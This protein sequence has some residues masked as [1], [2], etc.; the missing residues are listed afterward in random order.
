MK[1]IVFVLIIAPFFSFAQNCSLKKEIDK[2]SNEPKLTTGLVPLTGTVYLAIDANGKEIDF[3]FT[4]NNA[5]AKCFDESSTVTV[6]FNGR[7]KTNLKNTGATNC[8]GY[9][10]TTFRNSTTTPTV[11]Q[12]MATQKVT[13]L[14]IKDSN[15]KVTDITLTEEQTT[16]INNMVACITKEGKTL[17]K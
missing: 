1:K 3:Y 13:A 5:G 8:E 12:R 6:V 2:F 7:L 10:R 17:I 15:E 4:T 14:Q 11:L 16:M 9:F